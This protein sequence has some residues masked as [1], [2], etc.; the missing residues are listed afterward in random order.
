MTAPTKWCMRYC[1]LPVAYHREDGPKTPGTVRTVVFKVEVDVAT[2]D[3]IVEGRTVLQDDTVA[4]RLTAIEDCANE[5]EG[6]AWTG[7]LTI[8]DLQNQ[9]KNGNVSNYYCNLLM[10]LKSLEPEDG[11]NVAAETKQKV[12][13]HSATEVANCSLKFYWKQKLEP[14]GLARYGPI[15]LK[16]VSF[17]RCCMDNLAEML[18]TINQQQTDIR[19]RRSEIRQLCSENATLVN[20]LNTMSTEK[21]QHEKQ[22]LEKFVCILN[23]KK[24]RIQSQ[25]Q[26]TNTE[27]SLPVVN[28]NS[29]VNKN[30][31]EA[32][33]SAKRSLSC[34]KTNSAK[35]KTTII[36]QSF[37]VGRKEANEIMETDK[38]ADVVVDPYELD[39]QI[40]SP[41]S[42]SLGIKCEQTFNVG[43]KKANEITET[44]KAAGADVIDPY[45]LDTQ[46]DSPESPPVLSWAAFDCGNV[47]REH[48]HLP[49]AIPDE[50]SI[51][52][53]ATIVNDG[54]QSAAAPPQSVRR[55]TTMWSEDNY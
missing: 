47:Q 51:T 10:A 35:R 20:M 40:D 54:R 19:Q 45:E 46:I 34:K 3:A 49:V 21:Q 44:E 8:Q 43:R 28:R 4:L 36:E 1:S 12:F 6:R 48:A 41:E 5:A 32:T 24:K 14:F 29:T 25:Q 39:T 2:K 30:N 53:S 38:A 23:E 22:L 7:E 11:D 33:K 16:K 15:L 50:K 31:I 18:V 27:Q 26:T 13:V 42:S 9:C 55:Q 37:D 17:I 52:V